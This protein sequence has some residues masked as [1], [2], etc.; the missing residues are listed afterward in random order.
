MA[1]KHKVAEAILKNELYDPF[2]AAEAF[3]HAAAAEAIGAVVAPM[4]SA[5]PKP[6]SG[7]EEQ[8]MVL[9]QPTKEE[10]RQSS[11]SPRS[12]IGRWRRRMAWWGTCCK[13]K[14]P[15]TRSSS[16][17]SPKKMRKCRLSRTS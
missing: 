10:A 11:P 6:D 17:S 9:Q 13:T 3:E 2:G 14:R 1:E 16:F 8:P 15:R 4:A 7:L 12:L 5:G